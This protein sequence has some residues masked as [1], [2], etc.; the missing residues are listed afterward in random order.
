MNVR[1]EGFIGTFGDVLAFEGCLGFSR[2]CRCLIIGMCSYEGLSLAVVQCETGFLILHIVAKTKV[3]PPIIKLI[4]STT[5]FLA[6][7]S[8]VDCFNLSL[9]YLRRSWVAFY[10]FIHPL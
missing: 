5:S 2:S 7:T 4:W 8:G 9:D 3:F 6:F 1:V 10:F